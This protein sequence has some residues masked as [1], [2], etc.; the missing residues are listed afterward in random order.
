MIGSR[1]V[2]RDRS[3]R[4]RLSLSEPERTLLRSLPEQAKDLVTEQE[5]LARRLFPPAY[6]TDDEAEADYR[7]T[8]GASLLDRHRR[9]LDTLM[10]SVDAPGLDEAEAHDWLDALEVLRLVV[11]THLDISEE[12]EEVD[13]HDP[14]L[15][16]FVVYQYL[17]ELQNDVVEALSAGLPVEGTGAEPPDVPEP[18]LGSLDGLSTPDGLEGWL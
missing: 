8:A 11:G 7:R 15:A 5:P 10:D 13:E 3:G 2:R 17:T 14:R 12:F 9:S 18:D 1:R 6:P 16:H 4:Y